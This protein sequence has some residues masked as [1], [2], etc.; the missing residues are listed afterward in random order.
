MCTLQP[1]EIIEGETAKITIIFQQWNQALK[2]LPKID[3]DVKWLN[4]SVV[5]NPPQEW[6]N[7]ETVWE[8]KYL[9]RHLTNNWVF[10]AEGT[11]MP[12]AYSQS[13]Q[14]D[15]L[16]L[17]PTTTMVVGKRFKAAR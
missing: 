3:I 4:R 14:Q 9:R 17:T 11:Y 12:Q 16:N 1:N 5:T 10:S 7:V 2:I 8:A 15:D 6:I 13:V